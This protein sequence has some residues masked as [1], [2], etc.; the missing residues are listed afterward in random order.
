MQIWY[1]MTNGKRCESIQP[2]G[3]ILCKKDNGIIL[4]NI[5]T[6]DLGGFINLLNESMI[7]INQHISQSNIYVTSDLACLVS[8]LGKEHSSSHWCIQSK[9]SSNY[10]KIYVHSMGDE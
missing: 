7:L 6:K 9:L 3:Y 10:W 1:I 4:N 2:V 8:L 5:I